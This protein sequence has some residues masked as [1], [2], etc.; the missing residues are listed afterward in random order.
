MIVRVIESFVDLTYRGLS[1]GRRIRLCHVR[2]STGYLEI[3]APM[4][5]GTQIAITT[6]D[7]LAFDATVTAVQEPIAGSERTPGMTVA[8][9][10]TGERAA[11][12]WSARVALAD[13][14]AD[15]RRPRAVERSGPVP[16]VER[17]GPVPVVERSGPV[18]VVERSGPVPA[19]ERSGPARA[20][21]GSGPV[22]A[23]ER[24]GPARAVERSG[25]VTVHPRSHS[26]PIPVVTGGI[27]GAAT[28]ANEAA[29][30][31]RS[32]STARPP[33]DVHA[34]R[35]VVMPVVDLQAMAAASGVSDEETE[36]DATPPVPPPGEQTAIDGSDHVLVDDGQRT[37]LMDAVDPAM[38]GLSS[39]ESVELPSGDP[40]SP[41][42]ATQTGAPAAGAPGRGRRKRKSSP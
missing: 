39:V 20:V 3:P 33:E 16:V 13:P 40:E 31:A 37:I 42:D 28:S 29:A 9:A 41:G 26:S 22:P 2:P 4:P 21:G 14:D 15:E 24:S 1:L 17:S 8:P 25:P 12:W 6:E 5:V 38:L 7:G 35:T 27:E 19:V 34:A 10:L 30:A 11:A 32:A 23:V 36:A 18:P